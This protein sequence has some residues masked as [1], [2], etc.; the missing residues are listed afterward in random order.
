M[1]YEAQVAGMPDTDPLVR[2]VKRASVAELA[3]RRRDVVD[4]VEQ[5]LG[6]ALPLVNSGGTGSLETSA[7]AARVT[8]VTAGSGLLAPTLFDDYRAFT[9]RPAAFV[10]L[11]V[12]RVPGRGGRP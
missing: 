10:G 7:P 2:L 4:A 1:L 6:R 8:E 9:P 5:E 11:D 3:H 12:V